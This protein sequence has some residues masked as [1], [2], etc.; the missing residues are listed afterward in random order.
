MHIKLPLFFPN[1][2]FNNLEVRASIAEKEGFIE[3]LK[4]LPHNGEFLTL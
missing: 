3:L 4:T 1:R 2:P